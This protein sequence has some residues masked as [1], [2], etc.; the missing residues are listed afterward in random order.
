MSTSLTRE[1]KEAVGLLSIGTFLEYFD[2]M[3]YVHMAVLLNELFFPK[4]DPHTAALLSAFAFCSTYLLRPFG[5]L[6]FGWIGDNIGRKSTVII[7]T[8]MMSCS[9]VVMAIVPTYA[10]IGIAA[11]WI[12][13][14]CRITQGMSSMGEA[15]AAELYLTEITR[16]PVRYPTVAIVV[17]FAT[18]GGTA[19]LALASFV[20]S[21]NLNWRAAFFVGSI[22]AII[23]TV[24]RTALRETQEFADPNRRL[25]KVFQKLDQDIKEMERSP[26]VQEKVSNKTAISL[27][28]IQCLW[29]V[30]FYFAF[31]HCGNIF[32]STFH[33]TSEQVIHN[34]FFVSLA[35]LISYI[36]LAFMSYR[37]HPLKILKIK[38]I[39]F[40][41]LVLALPFFLGRLS[42][43]FE[44]FLIQTLLVVFVPTD[45]PAASVF[46]MHFP[47]FKRFTYVC[48]AY[49]ISRAFMS[50][51]V[52]FGL[53]Y[54]IHFF[55]NLG[56]LIVMLPITI[57]YYFGL[58]MFQRLEQEIEKHQVTV[59]IHQ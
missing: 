29:P 21:Y 57:G 9:C 5:A 52:S 15:T 54:L 33:Y 46:C 16:P 47:V 6:I 55:G 45:F 8:F 26:I 7:T 19:S 41:L 48:F 59:K 31:I 30:C 13:T 25:K 39:V 36:I 40:F 4:T 53:T 44:L 10:E 3:L 27:F 56:V 51:I 49:A 11:T 34:N 32:K 20:T 22:V 2:L 42:N 43:P 14:I 17:I 24:A 37:V 12:V 23:G 50:I 1:Q 18:I 38:W 58:N 35:Q 28:L